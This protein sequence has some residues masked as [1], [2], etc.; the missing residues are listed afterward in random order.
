MKLIK[1]ILLFFLFLII[2]LNIYAKEFKTN[3][4][5]QYFLSNQ[6]DS[7]NSEVKYTINIT[8]LNEGYYVSKFTLSFPDTFLIENISARDD[9]ASVNP[10]VS[11]KENNIN[12]ELVFNNPQTAIGSQNNFF[13]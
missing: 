7:I 2:P 5:V 10:V 6:R 11:N 13:D 3:Y 12:I 9:I 1:L 8:N 4:K